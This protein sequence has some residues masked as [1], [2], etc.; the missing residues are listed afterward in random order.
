[1]QMVAVIIVN[2]MMI[3]IWLGNDDISGPDGVK[4]FF[5]HKRNISGKIHIDLAQIMDMRR[6]VADRRGVGNIQFI[7]IYRKHIYG[8]NGKVICHL[9][10][11]LWA[12]DWILKAI[13][14]FFW[15]VMIILCFLPKSQ[16]KIVEKDNIIYLFRA[17]QKP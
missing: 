11:H 15:I 7:C 10:C 12:S 2:T 3:L 6:T 17:I 9:Y 14:M 1:M 13:S 16:W 5:H 8:S 4:A